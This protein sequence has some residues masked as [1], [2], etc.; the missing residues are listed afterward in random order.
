[1][2]MDA[3][4]APAADV[5][6]AEV[7]GELVL[8]NTTS[9]EY[10]GLNR[11]ATHIWQAMSHASTI[12]QLGAGLQATFDVDSVTALRDVAQLLDHLAESG[13]VIIG[14]EGR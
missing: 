5:I 1:M 4:V 3:R 14:G 7:D 12:G 8:L 10:F 9:G 11:V 13:L 6:S 2:S